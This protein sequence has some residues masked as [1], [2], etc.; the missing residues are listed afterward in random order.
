M[1]TRLVRHIWISRDQFAKYVMVGGSG[2]V[3]DM[4]TLI[5]FKEYLMVSATLAVILNQVI[6][7]TY[8]FTLNKYWSFAS[9]QM[10]HRQAVRYGLLAGFNYLLSALLMYTFADN[11]GYDYRLV[12][13]ATI[14]LM[15]LWNF[16]L[17]KH[18]VYQEV[19]D[20]SNETSAKSPE[21]QVS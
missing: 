19:C 9:R 8:N 12:R 14:A 6:V 21:N 20:V 5:G 16:L 4:L 17:Y 3:L 13:I 18:W 11:L 7:L 1:V 2:V 10:G 15:V